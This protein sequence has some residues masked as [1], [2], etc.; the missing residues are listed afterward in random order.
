MS[1]FSIGLSALNVNQQLLQLIGQNVSNANTPGYHRQVAA[2]AAK[3][4]GLPVG[5]GV[6][7]T[8]INR[9]I[10]NV[11]EQ[12][13]NNNTSAF[14]NVSTQLSGMHQVQSMLSPGSGSLNDLLQN[15]FS[16]AVQLSSNPSDPTQRQV[17]ISAA[18]AL[19]NG[20]NDLAGGLT[21]L[22]TNLNA[23]AQQ[24][25]TSANALLP[26]IAELNG[27]IQSATLSGGHPNDLMDQRDQLISS[28]ASIVN[29]QTIDEG[30]GM[31]GVIAG[32][33]PVVLGTQAYQ[34]Q[35]NAGSTPNSPTVVSSGSS[36]PLTIT[37]GQL[38]GLLNTANRA[39]PNVIQQL[40]TLAQQ[41]IQ[42]V[43]EIHATS[44]PLSGSFTT[45]TGTN[46]VSS[47]TL[48]L[49]QA[50][51]ALPPQAGSLSINVT[52][53]STGARTTTSIAIN[54]AMQSLQ[55]IATALSNVPH[56]QA[57]VTAP[58]DTLTITAQRGFA[59]DFAG[60]GN[61]DSA[62]LMS[63]LGL[64]SFF[65]GS[66][67]STIQV[68]SNL[69]ANPASLAVSQSGAPGD[70]T[71]LQRLAALQSAPVLANG[72]QS[73]QQFVQSLIGSTGSQVQELTQQQTAQQAV[74]QQL[75]AQ[76]QSVSS[77]D[78]NEE[79]VRLMQTQQSFQL[80]AHYLSVVG[81]SLEDLMQ[82]L[83]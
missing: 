2:L 66:D 77:V 68:N 47:N 59:F 60:S 49:A 1:S 62:N 24:A 61:T 56:I 64:N 40:N 65:Q 81:Q 79:L 28:L 50:G 48:A 71:A 43:N 27:E 73:M 52:D 12:A 76:Q 22:Q 57:I 6:D 11:L 14:Q 31:V 46:A 30:S 38:A 21:T 5:T 23:Q 53:T 8:G 72:T 58:T 80:A 13:I 15:F 63:A 3:S 67:A 16:Q 37:N 35:I 34:L 44:I 33:V 51:L 20:L 78:T 45:L 29:V 39:V 18:T 32:G 55:D 17:F 25:V 7:I 82:I 75:Q 4:D 70:G 26:Q 54:P 83:G 36:T 69:V 19:A 74:A 9:I 41:L 42:G 10:D